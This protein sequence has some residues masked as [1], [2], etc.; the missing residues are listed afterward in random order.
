MTLRPWTV[1][2][3]PAV[4]ALPDGA[5]ACTEAAS[6]RLGS[7]GPVLPCLLNGLNGT[8]LGGGLG[9]SKVRAL[10][11]THDIERHTYERI[12]RDAAHLEWVHVDQHGV[13]HLPLHRL[14]DRGIVVTKTASNTRP[15]AEHVLAMLLA[16]ARRL[17]EYVR[18]NGK[19]VWQREHVNPPPVLVR[20]WRVTI[21]GNGVIGTEVARLL[22]G[23]VDD[24]RLLARHDYHGSAGL[25]EAV[26]HSDALVLACPLTDGTRHLVTVDVL[27]ALRFG[28]VLVDVSRGG[29]LVE[30]AV[31][32]AL[33][34]GRL[35]FAALDVTRKEPLGADSPL[36]R[37]DVL[38]T[39]HEAWRARGT[40]RRRTE[41]FA[42]QLERYA[43]GGTAAL[44]RRV[45]LVAGY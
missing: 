45:N 35:S 32:A 33:D 39:P 36:W 43:E 16:G 17:P 44:Q 2:R 7:W 19:R 1:E 11:L 34:H 4:E 25:A 27:D 10:W 24:V 15:V 18:M 20:D 23:L 30:G 9:A 6:R 41:D 28:S 8:F 40:M 14:R 42:D 3:P 12:F 21:V 22:D 38:V 37:P 31:L 13:D 26:R 5:L 29:V